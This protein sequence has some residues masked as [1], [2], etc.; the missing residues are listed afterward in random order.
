MTVNEHAKER[1][2][3]HNRIKELECTPARSIREFDRREAEIRKCLD[4]LS[5]LR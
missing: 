4:R 5:E 1:L 2:R 3:L